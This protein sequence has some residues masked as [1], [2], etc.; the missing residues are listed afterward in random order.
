[1]KLLLLLLTLPAAAEPVKV[2]YKPDGSVAIQSASAPTKDC[3]KAVD[4]VTC[5]PSDTIDSSAL[6]PRASRDKWRRSKGNGVAA[7]G[8]VVTDQDRRQALLDELALLEAKLDDG[9]AT[10]ANMRRLLKIKMKLDG[11]SRTP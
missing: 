4:G 7:D 9:T 8:A 5:L 3:P 11:T 2:F 1:M 10:L 6:P